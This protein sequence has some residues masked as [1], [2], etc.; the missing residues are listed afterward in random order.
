MTPAVVVRVEI[1]GVGDLAIVLLIVRVL[2][3][4]GLGPARLWVYASHGRFDLPVFDERW[5]CWIAR[6]III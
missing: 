2:L 1:A 4:P 6:R 3:S 5:S